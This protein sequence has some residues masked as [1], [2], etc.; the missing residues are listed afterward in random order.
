[1]Q[2]RQEDLEIAQAIISGVVGF[3]VKISPSHSAAAIITTHRET[4]AQ[5]ERAAIV[6]WLREMKRP[7]TNWPQF[8]ARRIEVGEHRRGQADG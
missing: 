2:V 5:E 8:L 4:A 3:G 7:D 6:A 1:M